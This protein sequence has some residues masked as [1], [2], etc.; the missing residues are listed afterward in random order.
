M[1]AKPLK[2]T[3]RSTGHVQ[4]PGSIVQIYNRQ[5]VKFWVILIQKYLIELAW[6]IPEIITDNTMNLYNLFS[7][8]YKLASLQAIVKINELEVLGAQIHSD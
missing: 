8:K 2:D 5:K 7:C 3:T 4:K 6:F 1:R